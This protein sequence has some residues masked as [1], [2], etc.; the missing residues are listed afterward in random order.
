[1]FRKSLFLR[2]KALQLGK[3]PSHRKGDVSSSCY[4][5]QYVNFNRFEGS[6]HTERYRESAYQAACFSSI[7]SVPTYEMNIDEVT[8]LEQSSLYFRLASKVTE[9]KK[10]EETK[11][12]TNVQSIDSDRMNALALSRA[13]T[14]RL[15]YAMSKHDYNEILRLFK[16]SEEEFDTY[17]LRPDT[18]LKIF[19][20]LCYHSSNGASISL[21]DLYSVY[22]RYRVLYDERDLPLDP[23]VTK[24]LVFAI[25]KAETDSKTLNK[26]ISETYK[27]AIQQ[28]SEFQREVLPTM[29]VTLAMIPGNSVRTQALSILTLIQ[30]NNI[31]VN[32]NHFSKILDASSGSN[33][34]N[35]PRHVILELM[36]ERGKKYLDTS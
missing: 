22:C 13:L 2:S 6:C 9:A 31:E 1:M 33:F 27:F 7:P 5:P 4:L 18:I 15:E 3:R 25:A 17:S 20:I 14:G 11:I 16:K 29:L 32:N 10:S 8:S 34:R 24:T 36:I 12:E 21:S 35:V 28:D 23:K 19:N 26:V 30:K